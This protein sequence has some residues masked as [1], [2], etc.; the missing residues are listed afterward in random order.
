MIDFARTLV[1]SLLMGTAFGAL[2]QSPATSLPPVRFLLT[3][4][5]GP[6]LWTDSPTVTIRQQLAHNPVMPGVKALFFVQAVHKNHGGSDA[7]QRL[8]QE[9]CAEGHVLGL[10]SGSPRGHIPH[11]QFTPAELAESLVVGNAAI[12][13]QCPGTV[14]FVRPPDWVYN[15][16]TLA[17]YQ[18]AGLE[19]LQ[20]DISVNDGK[21]YGWTVSMRRRS[22]IHAGLEK[23]AQARR[24][25]LLPEVD[26]AFPVIV[27]LHDTNRYTAEHMTEYLQ[28][29][30]EES[31]DLGLPLASQPFYTDAQ[32]LARAGHVRAQKQLYVCAGKALSA[33]MLVR[34]GLAAGDPYKGC[35][36]QN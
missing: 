14:Q 1:L 21:I 33:P 5:D 4:D 35:F 3:F 26:G 36:V 19:M 9:A 23:V 17:A 22:H 18:A 13:Q 11:P 30:V 15:D 16:T 25:G 27:A 8:M 6:S 31:A 28:I 34:L 12:A 32:S 24:A 2:A 7:G 10:H 29:L 20:A